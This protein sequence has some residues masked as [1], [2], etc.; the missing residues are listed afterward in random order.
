MKSLSKHI[1]EGFHNSPILPLGSIDLKTGDSKYFNVYETWG[2]DTTYEIY[3]IEGKPKVKIVATAGTTPHGKIGD[4]KSFQHDQTGRFIFEGE[5][6]DFAVG[7]D[8]KNKMAQ[9]GKK[10]SGYTYK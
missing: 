2:E 4:Y 5:M 9:Y 6:I 10:I 7:T 3:K 1:N 8:L